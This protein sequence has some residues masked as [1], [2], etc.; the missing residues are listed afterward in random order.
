MKETKVY[1]ERKPETISQNMN[2]DWSLEVRMWFY[3]TDK[4]TLKDVKTHDRELVKEVCEK[5]RTIAHKVGKLVFCERCYKTNSA[6]AIDEH[7]LNEILGQIESE[8]EQKEYEK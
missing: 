5:I 7:L 6:R 2:D 3:H 4:V 1:V 8:F